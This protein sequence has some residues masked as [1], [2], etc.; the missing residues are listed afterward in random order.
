MK[1]CSSYKVKINSSNTRNDVFKPTIDI[2]RKAV[3]FY[4]EM[5]NNEWDALA[6]YANS[7]NAIIKPAESLS[8]QTKNNPSPKY[9]FDD[10]FYKMPCYLRRAA[11]MEASGI[12]SSYHSNYQNWINNGRK[13]S[14]PRLQT[15]HGCNPP[16]Y[17][18]N[19]FDGSCTTETGK[20][21]IFHKN[22]WIYYPVSFRRQD[23]KYIQKYW[24]DK[25]VSAPVLESRHGTYY[26]RFVFTEYKKLNSIPVDNQR[27]LAVDLGIN[28]NA[29]CSVVDADGTVYS[30]I[31]INTGYEKDH[32]YHSLNKLKKFQRQHGSRNS[33]A[34]WLRVN[35][36]NSD[37]SR[38]TA[39]QIIDAAVKN[40]ADCIVFEH[41]D[42]K[43]K[44]HGSKAQRIAIW[45]KKEIQD[46]VEH[47]A[48]RQGIRI[49][50]VNPAG[51]SKY[52]FD[53]SGKVQRDNKNYSLCKFATGKQY[54]CDLNASYNIGARYFIREI[55]KP[56]PE[57][58]RS[59]LEAEVPSLANRTCCTLSSLISLADVLKQQTA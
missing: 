43:G 10:L 17:Y 13:G 42:I 11:I 46:I 49:S 5:I 3:K 15:N 22:D 4:I 9:H 33:Q 14:S 23:I 36:I 12:V 53:G 45:R 56:L 6:D 29:V 38:K 39:H 59:Q 28:N 26:L 34:M 32:L 57:T 7:L 52:A 44:I 35:D 54:N 19:M 37:I 48:H 27:V 21:K 55:L 1:I 41:L 31:F 2:Y 8:H 30:R 25:K 20:I 40:N 58:E 18:N 50:R 16:M 24:S 51:T 47:Q